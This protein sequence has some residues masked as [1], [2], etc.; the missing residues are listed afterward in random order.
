MRAWSD[1]RRDHGY[2]TAADAVAVTEV[3]KAVG[4]L[5]N[6]QQSGVH[7]RSTVEHGSHENVMTRA[8][9]E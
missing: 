3:E 1:G 2:A 4:S 6:E 8:V 5:T 7:H 9:H